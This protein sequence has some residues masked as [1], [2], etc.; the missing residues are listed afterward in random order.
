MTE[1]VLAEDPSGVAPLEGA[2]FVIRAVARLIDL[3]VHYVVTV[4]ASLGTALFVAVGAAVLGFDFDAAINDAIATGLLGYVAAFLGST[5]L[6]VASE[7]LHGSTLGKLICGLTVIREDGS[8]P[9]GFM[10]GFRRELAFYPDSLFFG[11]V[12]WNKM[13][14]SPRCQRIGDT[15]AHTMVVRRRTVPASSRPSTLRFL[16][17]LGLGVFGDSVIIFTSMMLRLF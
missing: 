13:N 8:A 5:W 1:S 10:A 11:L 2:G 4:A 6:Q 3:A 15:W 17:G 14:E 16:A 12:A 9:P 7:S